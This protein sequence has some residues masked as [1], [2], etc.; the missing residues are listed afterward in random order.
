MRNKI[1]LISEDTLKT[2]S[3]IGDNLD[4]KYLANSLQLAQDVDLANLLGKALYDKI[5]NLVDTDEIGLPANANYK[6]LLD[7][8]IQDYLIWQTMSTVQVS[9]NWKFSNSGVYQNQDDKKV[10]IEYQAGKNLASQYEKYANAYATKMKD[11]LMKNVSK[12]PEYC[13]CKDYEEALDVNLC[14]IYFD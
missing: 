13:K 11:Y 6:Y 5:L 8:Y 10:A 2:Y 3:L 1:Y 9:I 4:G 14:G 7:N 12:Y